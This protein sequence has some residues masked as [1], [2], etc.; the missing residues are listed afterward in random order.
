MIH[1]ANKKPPEPPKAIIVLGCKVRGTVPS[2]ML[3][4]R[5]QAAYDALQ[6][7]PDAIAIVSGGKGE[8]ENI[9]EAECMENELVRMG[10]SKERIIQENQSTS[11]S[12][13][14]RFSKPI[15]EE[16]GID[17]NV[18]I[19]T[20]GYHELR[21]QYLAKIEQLPECYG[22]SAYTS[23]YLLPTYWVREW[24]GL[25]HAFVFKD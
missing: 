21:A 22:A 16:K 11:T 19:V 20:D 23:F 18:L 25:A 6:E 3:F 10:I 24:F 8:N 15:L 9:S 17:K 14:L 4:R 12:E 7:Y 2:L 5:I 1:A 13:N